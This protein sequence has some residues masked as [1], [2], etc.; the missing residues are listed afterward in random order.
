[1]GWADDAR[2]PLFL[3]STVH[4]EQLNGIK[5]SNNQQRGHSKTKKKV[6]EGM[7]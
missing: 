6:E 1:V 2:G 5:V 7:G 4:L 3:E